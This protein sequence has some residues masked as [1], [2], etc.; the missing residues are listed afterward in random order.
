MTWGNAWYRGIMN[1]TYR[2]EKDLDEQLRTAA[3]ITRRS[4]QSILDEALRDWLDTKGKAALVAY[5][6]DQR[7]GQSR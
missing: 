4:K 5:R 7:R 3:F 6:A 1:M 2:P